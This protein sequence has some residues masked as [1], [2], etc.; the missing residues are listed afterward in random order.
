MFQSVIL[1]S[2][3]SVAQQQVRTAAA[4][5]LKLSVTGSQIRHIFSVYGTR[6][7]RVGMYLTGMAAVLFWP[8]ATAYLI[9][10]TGGINHLL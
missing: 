2:A 3:A 4:K 7:P 10:A 8:Q 5:P 1:R 9:D 6:I